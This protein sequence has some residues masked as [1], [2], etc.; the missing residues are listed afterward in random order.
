VSRQS[1]GPES[2]A[3]AQREACAFCGT[4]PRKVEHRAASGH[5]LCS[6]CK[7]MASA[8]FTKAPWVAK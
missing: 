2:Q 1:T 8:Y 7:G 3:S 4:M 6:R 5:A